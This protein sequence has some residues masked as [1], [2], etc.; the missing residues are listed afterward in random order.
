MTDFR[1]LGGNSDDRDSSGD[2]SYFFLQLTFVCKTIQ[3]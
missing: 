3:T 2:N 1:V